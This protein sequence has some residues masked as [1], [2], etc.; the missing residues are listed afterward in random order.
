MSGG[1]T[2]RRAAGIPRV[3][4]IGST[5]PAT[6][7]RHERAIGFRRRAHWT[8][9]ARSVTTAHILHNQAVIYGGLRVLNPRAAP[10]VDREAWFDTIRGWPHSRMVPRRECRRSE[11]RTTRSRDLIRR[12]IN[13]DA[14]SPM[15]GLV[16]RQGPRRRGSYRPTEFAA[17]KNDTC[18]H[19]Q[20]PLPSQ[21]ARARC[22]GSAAARLPPSSR[23]ARRMDARAFSRSI[24]RPTWRPAGS[25][26]TPAASID[27]LTPVPAGPL[28]PAGPVGRAGPRLAG[29]PLCRAT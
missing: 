23:T 3:C 8:P 29:P 22:D 21:G 11:H 2:L 17:R 12:D 13:P 14:P 5:R 10:A 16:E 1:R 20:P 4:A 18:F 7:L 26:A 6:A 28:G 9:A 25:A 19:E 15:R 27:F 24:P